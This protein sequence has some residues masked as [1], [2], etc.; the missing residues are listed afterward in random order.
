MIYKRAA[1]ALDGALERCVPV[2]ADDTGPG[3]AVG[4]AGILASSASKLASPPVAVALAGCDAALVAAEAVPDGFLGS[5][6]AEARAA[7]AAAA[8]A[9][10]RPPTAAAGV[11]ATVAPL[12]G[13]AAVEADRAAGEDAAIVAAAPEPTT[14]SFPASVAAARTRPRTP[15]LRIFHAAVPTSAATES[16]C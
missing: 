6:D 8:C 10:V 7:G 12:T 11:A 1:P 3:T 14:S 16:P 2:A 9:V 13:D 15:A 5:V 4:G